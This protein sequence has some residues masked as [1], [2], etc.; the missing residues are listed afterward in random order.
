MDFVI[1]LILAGLLVSIYAGS[2]I[3]EYRSRVGSQLLYIRRR[4][5]SSTNTAERTSP[6]ALLFILASG[7]AR[8]VVLLSSVTTMQAP[9]E[10][11]LGSYQTLN[12]TTNTRSIM[13]IA[14]QHQTVVYTSLLC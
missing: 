5:P 7:G 1:V 6:F 3:G 8:V 9:G 14:T 10:S 4:H 13:D 12:H 11:S 2:M